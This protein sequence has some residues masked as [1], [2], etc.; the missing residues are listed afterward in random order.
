MRAQAPGFGA[1]TFGCWALA[2]ASALPV[3]AQT[4]APARVAL[5]WN[6]AAA[7]PERAAAQRALDEQLA[8]RA[9]DAAPATVDIAITREGAGPFRA[10]VSTRDIHGV[11]ERRFEGQSCERVVEAAVLIASMLLETGAIAARTGGDAPLVSKASEP[12]APAQPG[13]PPALAEKPAETAAKPGAAS[14]AQFALGVR[15]AGDIGSL[16]GP[17]LGAGVVLA[18]HVDRFRAELDAT[19]WLPRLALYDP[20][21]GSGGEVGLYGANLR[22]CYEVVQFGGPAGSRLGLSPCLGLEAGLS[23]GSGVKLSEADRARGFWGA[24]FAGISFAQRSRA[25]LASWIAI[26]AG[27]AFY[28]PNYV[29]V[30]EPGAQDRVFRAAPVVARAVLGV[31]WLFR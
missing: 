11:G 5:Q 1:L 23:V 21:A 2:L 6:A 14:S 26:E 31:Q 15:V 8:R 4:G 25:G 17:S 22:A 9:P 20:R 3:A 24:T 29:F 16:P 13:S 28:R 10:Q 7:C 30:I 27:W 12:S 19:A 18:V